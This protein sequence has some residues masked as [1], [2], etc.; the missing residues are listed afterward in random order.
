MAGG[1]VEDILF[2]NPAS[3]FEDPRSINAH[4]THLS[5]AV[6]YNARIMR[7]HRKLLLDV[8]ALSVPEDVAD[9]GATAG[10][11]YNQAQLQAVMDKIDEIATAQ[12]AI[13]ELLSALVALPDTDLEP[14]SNEQS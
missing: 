2:P 14:L 11:A 10:G 3:R 8:A 7:Q 1:Q 9:L 5:L 13:I 4:L 6:H 12:R